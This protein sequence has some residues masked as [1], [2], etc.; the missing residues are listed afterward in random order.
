MLGFDSQDTI[1]VKN[2]LF[3]GETGAEKIFVLKIFWVVFATGVYSILKERTNP[4]L[5]LSTFLIKA[6]HEANSKSIPHT[7]RNTLNFLI[8]G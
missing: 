5:S 6:H 8:G 3:S 1:R 4:K 7:L 2:E